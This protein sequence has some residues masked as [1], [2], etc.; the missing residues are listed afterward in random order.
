MDGV[1]FRYSILSLRYHF[2]PQS[3]FTLS[4]GDNAHSS[5]PYISQWM[6]ISSACVCSAGSFTAGPA[7][8][9]ERY[10][11]IT[12]LTAFSISSVLPV[13]AISPFTYTHMTF[14]FSSAIVSDF[15]NLIRKYRSFRV[16]SSSFVH[17]KYVQFFARAFCFAIVQVH[18]HTFF[19]SFLSS[20]IFPLNQL[21]TI[22]F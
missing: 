4:H 6:Q 9:P 22:H 13:S 1:T 14:S 15:T 19:V 17:S 2:H 3:L 7:Y 21:K 10:C 18:I 20:D 8:I 11:K 16:V 12:S 5:L